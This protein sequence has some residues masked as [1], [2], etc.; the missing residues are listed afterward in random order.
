MAS[1]GHIALGMAAARRFR[2]AGRP[3]GSIVT[4]MFVWSGLSMLPDADVLGFRFGIAY[5]AAWGHRGATHSIA[6]AL[7]AG[8]VLGACAGMVGL[9]RVRTGLYATVVVCSHALLDT[10]TDGGLGCALLW[11]FKMRRYFLPWRPIPVAPIGRAFF[12]GSGLHVAWVE[13][14]LFAPFFVYACWPRGGG[15]GGPQWS[16]HPRRAHERD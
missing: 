14:L 1:I 7:V 3:R 8:A 16:P 9:P 13:M 15:R 6:F 12:S 5:A 2:R 10:M 4:A 11:P